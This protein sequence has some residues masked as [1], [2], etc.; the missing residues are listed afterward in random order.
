M[1]GPAP[2]PPGPSFSLLYL[3]FFRA[4]DLSLLCLTAYLHPYELA[5]AYFILG[6]IPQHHV[7]GPQQ[8]QLWPRELRAGSSAPGHSPVVVI[9]SVSFRHSKT[10]SPGSPL[11]IAVDDADTSESHPGFRS[12]PGFLELTQGQ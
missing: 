10:L 8:S 2:A 12:R 9:L 6:T 3:E 5:D 11:S 7:L 4:G 1:G